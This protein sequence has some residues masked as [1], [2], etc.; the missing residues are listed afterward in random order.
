[1]GESQRHCAKQDKPLSKGSILYDFVC[2]AFSERQNYNDGN[3]DCQG[4]G[5][6]GCDQRESVTELWCCVLSCIPVVVGLESKRASFSRLVISDS[7]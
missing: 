2:L 3:G 6:G 7:L 5:R 4:E 1:M